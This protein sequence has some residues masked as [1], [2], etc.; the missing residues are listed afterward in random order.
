MN[1]FIKRA[2]CPSCQ[3]E[4]RDKS[5]N[6]LAVYKEPTGKYNAYCFACRAYYGEWVEGRLDNQVSRSAPA[7]ST[8][9]DADLLNNC[10]SISLLDRNI[11]QEITNFYG[12][13]SLILNDVETTRAYPVKKKGKIV[14]YKVRVL[15][16]MFS[17]VGDVK[18]K[19]DFFGQSL[20]NPTRT[21][22]IIITEGE[23]DALAVY[24]MAKVVGREVA[25][26]SG[27]N[28]ISNLKKEIQA[29]YMWLNQ[30]AEVI[31]CLDTDG[32]TEGVAEEC[33]KLLNPRK[34]RIATLPVKDASEMCVAHQYTEF[35]DAIDTA[36][37]LSLQGVSAGQ[38][39]FEEIRNGFTPTL[40]KW[41]KS[42]GVQ[43]P[44]FFTPSIVSV[45]AGTG[46]GKSS[47]VKNLH[48]HMRKTYPDVKVGVIT[49]EESKAYYCKGLLGI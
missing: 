22:T 49:L 17:N 8:S 6:N 5:G 12:V 4:G 45:A 13:K 35:W 19:T 26:V 39:L 38:D 37:G 41:P 2:A 1:K 43:G 21:S 7:A 25:A 40:Y 47:L 46:S 32:A 10:P 15:P 18:G 20:F 3:S 31:F 42:W 23:E 48:Y 16:K 9:V 30:F 28:G 36:L 24:R 27:C 34:V 11:P 33:A 29:N 44:G 14:G